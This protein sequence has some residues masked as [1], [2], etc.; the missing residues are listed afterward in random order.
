MNHNWDFFKNVLWDVPR[1]QFHSHEINLFKNTPVFWSGSKDDNEKKPLQYVDT[2]KI[3]HRIHSQNA[4][5]PQTY[6]E[7][8]NTPKNFYLLQG[9]MRITESQT[10]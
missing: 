3:H 1:T 10:H 4:T 5:L 9:M 2:K 7:L 8:T 6:L